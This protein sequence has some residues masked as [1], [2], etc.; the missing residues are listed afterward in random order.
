MTEMKTEVADTTWKKF[1]GLMLKSK[2]K[3]MLFVFKRSSRHSFHT[4]F[5][6]FPIDF[7][8]MDENKKVVEIHENVKPWR[9]VRPQT[10]A[11]YVLELP[12]GTAKKKYKCGNSCT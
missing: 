3:P 4:C 12:A 8:F 10:P 5:M 2:P 6:R 11:M 9:F 1:K 7:V